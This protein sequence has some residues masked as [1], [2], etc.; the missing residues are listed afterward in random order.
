[1]RD[2]NREELLDALRE[3][4]RRQGAVHGILVVECPTT[5]CPVGEIP[6]RVR[7]RAGGHLVQPKLKCP[8]CGVE[9]TFLRLE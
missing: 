6:M 4:R 5:S 3:Q 8:R 2:A 7:E 1:M 9:A